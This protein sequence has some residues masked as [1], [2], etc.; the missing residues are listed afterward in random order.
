[1]KGTKEA[2]VE[3]TLTMTADE[4]QWLKEI[5]QNPHGCTSE[6]EDTYTKDMRILFWNVLSSAIG[7]KK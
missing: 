7:R 6:Q 3:I 1:M 5:M 2:S 4:A